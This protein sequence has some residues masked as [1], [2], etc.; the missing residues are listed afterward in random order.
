M[1]KIYITPEVEEYK[2]YLNA[3]TTASGGVYDDDS[4]ADDYNGKKDVL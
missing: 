3:I 2:L 1:K 4:T